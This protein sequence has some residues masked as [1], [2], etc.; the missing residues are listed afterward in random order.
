[1]RLVQIRRQSDERF[2]R[3][4]ALLLKSAT[5]LEPALSPDLI[6]GR[7]TKSQL[8]ALEEMTAFPEFKGLV[9]SMAPGTESCAEWLTFLEHPTAELVVPDSWREGP[10]GAS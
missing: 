8:A 3:L 10:S 1:M 9:E 2:T 6:D 4:F 5:V 7:L